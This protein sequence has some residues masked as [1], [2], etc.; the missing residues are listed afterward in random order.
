VNDDVE[1]RAALELLVPRFDAVE[2]D[3]A[4][5]LRRGGLVEAP[6]AL[7]RRGRFVAFAL[8]A[9][10]A[11]V[12]VAGALGHG[13]VHRTLDELGA[14][15]GATPGD[16]APAEEQRRFQQENEQAFTHFPPGTKVGL[17]AQ[18]TYD[19]Q[20]YDLLGFRDGPSL[21]VRLVAA[22][23]STSVPANCA[24]H[25][26]LVELG[27]PAAVFNGEEPLPSAD[28]VA[29]AVYGV[30]ADSVARV[31]IE[32]AKSGRHRATLSGN[33]FVYVGPPVRFHGVEDRGDIATRAIVTE[34]DGTTTTIPIRTFPTGTWPDAADLPGPV[35]TDY[36]LTDSHVA[37]L[38]NGEPRGEPYAWPGDEPPIQTARLLH[39]NPASSFGVGVAFA[40]AADGAENGDW[41]C[42]AWLWPLAERSA[43]Y[44]CERDRFSDVTI[45]A[46]WPSGGEQFPL[47][48][49]FAADAVARMELF[50]AN[51]A[52]ENVPITDNVYA[53]TVPGSMGVK[54]VAYDAEGRVVGVHVLGF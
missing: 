35:D 30:A 1:I 11:G 49:G 8:A 6:P 28:P 22:G 5:A 24:P 41:Y 17:L 14:W 38:E 20:T 34:E 26:Q 47:F 40:K 46:A 4:D 25:R 54:L 36:T 44:G 48:V 45:Q 51:G 23:G 10:L 43:S 12:L 33:A 50:F 15:V 27:R 13:I 21:C 19:A 37:W 2:G 3:W 16:E 7:H 42:L 39:P 9:A 29:T 32:T 53:V 31:E 18:T 52:R